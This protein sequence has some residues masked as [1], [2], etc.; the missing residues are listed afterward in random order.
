MLLGGAALTA[1]TAAGG[2]SVGLVAALGSLTVVF[3][4]GYWWAGRGQ[5]DVAALAASRPDERQRW[6]DLKATALA[7]IVVCVF[8]LGAAVVNLA[9]GGS[10]YPW[11]G[12]D[13]LFGASY[14]VGF[15]I[16]RRFF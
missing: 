13:A 3:T 16:L 10:G 5:G 12:I 6:L 11:V 2:G 7:G 14:A 9:R 1:A 15:A 4:A 8:C